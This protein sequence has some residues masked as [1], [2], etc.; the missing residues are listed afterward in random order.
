MWTEE[1]H[2]A[3][4]PHELLRRSSPTMPMNLLL[5]FLLLLLLFLLLLPLL[6]LLLLLMLLLLPLLSVCCRRL[7]ILQHFL[8]Q[9]TRWEQVLQGPPVSFIASVEC[10]CGG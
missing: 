2:S 6:L 1:E 8:R 3:Q 9:S 5:L 10:E 7:Y 4:L